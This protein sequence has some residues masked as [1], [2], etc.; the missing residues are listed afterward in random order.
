MQVVFKNDKVV[1][2]N[3]CVSR[4]GIL[5]IDRSVRKSAVTKCVIDADDIF[6]LQTIVPA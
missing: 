4:I 3:L 5:D 6:M 1:P 2:F